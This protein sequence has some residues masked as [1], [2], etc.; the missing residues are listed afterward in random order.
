MLVRPGQTED[1]QAQAQLVPRLKPRS[2]DFS[3]VEVEG[4]QDVAVAT[5]DEEAASLLA[6]ITSGTGILEFSPER[7][8]LDVTPADL[9]FADFNA[10]SRPKS[11]QPPILSALAG[12]KLT[13]A[14][15]IVTTCAEEVMFSLWLFVCS[16]VC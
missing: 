14:T 5:S 16:F 15:L 10:E 8:G 4:S 11:S 1:G 7:A 9:D 2:H 13:T 6:G 12:Q 3:S